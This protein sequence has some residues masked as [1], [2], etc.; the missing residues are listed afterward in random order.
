M[1]VRTDKTMDREAYLDATQRGAINVIKAASFGAP[2]AKRS[3]AG[4][5]THI[6]AAPD[7]PLD[8][9][10]TKKRS[11]FGKSKK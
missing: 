6:K 5:D 3:L 1:S 9:T 7:K 8:H 4:I 11:L 2:E 10:T